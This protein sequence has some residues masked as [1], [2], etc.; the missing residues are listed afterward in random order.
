MSGPDPEPLRSPDE[1]GALDTAPSVGARKHDG[2]V[3]SGDPPARAAD[4]TTPR[5]ESR[6][7]G[8]EK[9]P[10]ARPTGAEAPDPRALRTTLADATKELRAAKAARTEILARLEDELARTTDY[11]RRREL[12]DARPRH[13]RPVTEAQARV[14][15]AEHELTKER[16]TRAYRPEI[17][18]IK[19]LWSDE[20][21]IQ[22]LRERVEGGERL[23][24]V[25]SFALIAEQIRLTHGKRLHDVQLAGAIAMD[26]G[27]PL[28]TRIRFA[29]TRGRT[30]RGNVVEMSTGEGKTFTGMLPAM[31]RGFENRVAGVDGRGVHVMTS[32]SQL[33]R[34]AVTAY[35]KV[36]SELGLTVRL[37]SRGNPGARS[38]YEAD[39]TIG[40]AT[41]LIFDFLE[42]QRR[43][44]AE[45]VQRGHAFAL[46]DEADMVMLDWGASPHR[47]AEAV[48]GS[49]RRA[50]LVRA[51][52]VA[53]GLERGEY[54]VRGGG[55][56]T[57]S[58]RQASRIEQRTGQ[59]LSDQQRIDLAN[60]A[61]AERMQLD[62][63]Y[64]IADRVRIEV[65]D[66]PNGRAKHGQRWSQ[67]LHE[68]LEAKHKL[69]IGRP[70]QTI[71][72]A[73]VVQ[74]LRNYRNAAAMTG[75]AWE[76][77]GLFRN[78]FRMDVVRIEP[79][80]PSRL[81]IRQRQVYA[82]ERALHNALATEVVMRKGN[83]APELLIMRT[84]AQ[85]EAF[86]AI[87][88]ERGV[89]VQV[90]NALD[91]R[92]AFEDAVVA[93]AGRPYA[94]TVATN[95]IGR[96]TD[97]ILGGR[98]KGGPV[99]LPAQRLVTEAGGLRVT[100]AGVFESFR[101]TR[102]GFGRAG[103]QGSP[104]SAGEVL[105]LDDPILA[106]YAGKRALA[107]LEK[108][109]GASRSPIPARAVNRLVERAVARAEKAGARR[110]T[111]V[112]R[113]KIGPETE[114]VQAVDSTAPA[115]TLSRS[116]TAT[117]IAAT[118]RDGLVDATIGRIDGLRQEL[119]A[120]R[121]AVARFSGAE[122]TSRLL[123][124]CSQ[125]CRVETAVSQALQDYRDLVE[126][127][128]ERQA[129]EGAQT[130]SAEFD[131]IAA[132]QLGV[133]TGVVTLARHQATAGDYAGAAETL[134]QLSRGAEAVDQLAGR[135]RGGA[136]W[137]A[138]SADQAVYLLQRL[139]AIQQGATDTGPTLSPTA[140][141]VSRLSRRLAALDG[142][143]AHSYEARE[144]ARTLARLDGLVPTLPPGAAA[145]VAA[146]V[147][148]AARQQLDRL[149]QA[150]PPAGILADLY[151]LA[152]DNAVG[153]EEIRTLLQAGRLAGQGRP[154]RAIGEFAGRHHVDWSRPAKRALRAALRHVAPEPP[155]PAAPAPS[156]T[157]GPVA[158]SGD[159][160]GMAATATGSES[161]AG[162]RRGVAEPVRP[163]E[164]SATLPRPGDTA[165]GVSPP[166]VVAPG[167]V[168]SGGRRLYLGAVADPMPGSVTVDRRARPD[169]DVIADAARL[170]FRSNAFTEVHAVNPS[171]FQPVSAET[172][173][174]LVPGGRL[175]VTGSPQNP[176]VHV[177]E[178][179]VLAAG[180][181]RVREGPAVAEHRRSLDH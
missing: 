8:K 138:T 1:A 19:T 106:R 137:A 131:R 56:V 43:P 139:V 113:G 155:L 81:N 23:N 108:T 46:V 11:S 59:V 164:A 152:A 26:G 149:R 63:D 122:T 89:T 50:E 157:A 74:Y 143:V 28:S 38:A 127:A 64:K 119:V 160:A 42:D 147:D 30:A 65:L 172:A 136:V 14:D 102:Q 29:L 57:I 32:D 2:K 22:A 93:A 27:G 148:D 180:F 169:V 9:T 103:R 146:L 17:T 83:P 66:N 91:E 6:V 177:S 145:A 161:A 154:A 62:W 86:A 78:L 112:V 47:L 159:G 100:T 118:P 69:P 88:R 130:V 96:G 173:R 141:E 68:A 142:G 101:A 178:A 48:Q 33:A 10:P 133:T 24:R 49:A 21:G 51:R 158:V 99:D 4:D 121:T 44:A 16:R 54:S 151:R 124:E 12:L 7:R 163:T 126:P 107:R 153:A 37:R 176:A 171:G 5:S 40:S 71:A 134:S 125:L 98:G 60:A 168:G 31:K 73:T 36:A 90:L 150:N 167:P 132:Q 77:R 92:I 80:L 75:T 181:V 35:R 79:N 105:S 109:Y 76:A 165:S 156:A 135:R 84:P 114:V 34:G 58:R 67:G 97:I 140:T 129:A 13:D 39:I 170:P 70:Q 175:V 25:E 72:Q 117:D 162:G 166:A 82:S 20:A 41:D 85:A 15:A 55:P 95:I 179:D 45:R 3:R 94:V 128:V 52:D 104:G 53:R 61:L 110:L 87:L 116:A 144:L 174:V 120:A 115:S 123:D 111:E 18:A